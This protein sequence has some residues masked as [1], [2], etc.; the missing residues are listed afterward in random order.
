MERGYARSNVASKAV[1]LLSNVLCA[2]HVDTRART[3]CEEKSDSCRN[4]I[5]E[6]KH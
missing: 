5:D 1:L 4:R 6:T 2:A 3:L